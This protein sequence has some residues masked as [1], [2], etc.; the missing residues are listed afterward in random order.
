MFD[1]YIKPVSVVALLLL[2]GACG[3]QLRGEVK[4]AQHLLPLHIAESGPVELRNNIRAVLRANNIALAKQSST[5]ASRLTITEAKQSR[6]VLS[7]DSRGRVREYEMNYIV[8]YLITTGSSGSIN[9]QIHLSRELIFDPDS[10][11]A[12]NDET[13]TLYADMQ[14]DASRLILQ[15]LQAIK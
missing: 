11:L 13:Q 8:N 2:I 4:L 7:V 6:R 10:V 1:S 3:F 15:Q 5:A 12:L 9:K 14:K